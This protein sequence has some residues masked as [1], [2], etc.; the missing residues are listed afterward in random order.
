MTWS[1]GY[2]GAYTDHFLVLIRLRLER[3]LGS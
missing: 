1:L 2:D 3:F